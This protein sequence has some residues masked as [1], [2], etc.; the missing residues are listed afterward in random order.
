MQIARG[1][2]RQGPPLDRGGEGARLARG[3]LGGWGAGG[4][5][6]LAPADKP[7]VRPA[8]SRRR[9]PRRKLGDGGARRAEGGRGPSAAGG[10]TFTGVRLGGSV[11]QDK[12]CRSQQDFDRRS[13]RSRGHGGERLRSRHEGRH[14]PRGAGGGAHQ[15]AAGRKG[16]LG[17]SRLPAG[18]RRYSRKIVSRPVSGSPKV[19]VYTCISAWIAAWAAAWVRAGAGYLCKLADFWP[20]ALYLQTASLKARE[21]PSLSTAWRAA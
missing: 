8:Q 14:S 17:N 15:G 6:D 1:D 10:Q 7:F 13:E 19:A 12:P 11:C 21:C 2:G 18:G 20:V 16:D 9:R 4:R 5:A 3:P